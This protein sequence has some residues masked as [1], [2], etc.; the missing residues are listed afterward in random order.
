MKPCICCGATKPLVE[1]YTHQM[2]ADGHLNKCKICCKAHAAARRA[3]N[4][5]AARSYDRERARLPH[6]AANATAVTRR[7][8][9]LHPRKAR[10]Q[11]I[12]SRAL[13]DGSLVPKPCEQCSV[14][15]TFAHHDDY[16]EPLTVRWL[17]GV[18][19]AA[20]H[21]LNGPGKNRT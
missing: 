18:H 7:L 8:R 3:A 20:W 1:F 2:M 13:R 19:H 10:A 9:K 4:L 6:R 15:E 5:D 12:V 11:A 14:P 21:K 17:C 16:A